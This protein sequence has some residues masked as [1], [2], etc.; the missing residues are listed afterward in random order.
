MSNISTTETKSQL[1]NSQPK[2]CVFALSTRER[3]FSISILK[4]IGPMKAG[5]DKNALNRPIGPDDQRDWSFGLFDCFPRCRL[6]K[7]DQ[8]SQLAISHS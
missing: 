4:A 6:C 1:I 8:L 7:T 5:G 3:V 2:V